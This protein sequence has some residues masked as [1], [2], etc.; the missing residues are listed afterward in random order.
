LCER[1]GRALFCFTTRVEPWE[2]LGFRWYGSFRSR[3]RARDAFDALIDLVTRLGH[4]EPRTR[5]RELP[6][7]RGARVVGVRRLGSRHVSSLHRFLAGESRDALRELAL[8]LLE[9]PQARRDAGEIQE[10]LGRLADF[11]ETDLAKLRAALGRL[12]RKVAFVPQDERD[13]L[14][15]ASRHV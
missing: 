2:A 14:F 12:G 9:K 4:R 5:L 13:A 10:A 6:R 7:L 3:L 15:I 11:Y 1:E 8:A